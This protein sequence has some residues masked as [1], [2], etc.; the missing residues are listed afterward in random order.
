[1]KAKSKS[2]VKKRRVGAPSKRTPEVE[3][4]LCVAMS[5]GLPMK[6]A[7]RLAGIDHSTFCDWR[8]TDAE[9]AAKIES[10]QAEGISRRLAAIED[11]AA[12]GDWKASAWI[13]ERCYPS[14]FARNR[15]EVNYSGAVGVQVSY[16]VPKET[17]DS[18]AEARAR[19]DR[20]QLIPAE[21]MKQISPPPPNEEAE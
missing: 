18:I 13:L 20:Q 8:N 15:V 17:L 1:M 11:A 3:K 12:G 9:F 21:V 7:S 2:V 5:R 16:V 6:H 14:E 19:Y 4:L 10:A